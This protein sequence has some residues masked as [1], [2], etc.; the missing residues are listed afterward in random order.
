MYN[1]HLEDVALWPFSNLVTFLNRVEN[2]I[3]V[4]IVVSTAV[5]IISTAWSSNS[6]VTCCLE[7]QQLPT[8]VFIVYYCR[9]QLRQSRTRNFELPSPVAVTQCTSRLDCVL[10]STQG[11]RSNTVAL[12]VH[13]GASACRN[14]KM[15]LYKQANSSQ[16]SFIHLYTTCFHNFARPPIVYIPLSVSRL[17]VP[18][19][20]NNVSTH[21][22]CEQIVS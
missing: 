13:S 3:F 22:Q 17:C 5:A 15:L 9:L 4:C 8:E 16:H 1:A 14:F 20:L 19:Y 2:W 21:A 6:N 7:R 10:P 12:R 18:V 11:N